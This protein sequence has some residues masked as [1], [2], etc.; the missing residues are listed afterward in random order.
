ME[1]LS[2][3]GPSSLNKQ[4]LKKLQLLGVSLFRVNLSH[5]EV[6]DLKKIINFVRKHSTVPI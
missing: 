4:T 1:L 3:L 6:R 2:T 5:T